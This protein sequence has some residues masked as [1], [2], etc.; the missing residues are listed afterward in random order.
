MSELITAASGLPAELQSLLAEIPWPVVLLSAGGEIL[1]M[2]Q[3]MLGLLGA[4]ATVR[5]G[6]PFEQL[7][8]E[9]ERPALRALLGQVAARR[10]SLPTR[11]HLSHGAQPPIEVEIEALPISADSSGR[12]T[13]N[14]HPF[15]LT[16]RRERLLLEINRLAS[17]LLA[18]QSAD[19]VFNRATEALQPLGLRM[20]VLTLDPNQATLSTSYLSFSSSRAAYMRRSGGLQVDTIRI[21]VE[22]SP[23]HEVLS[24]RKTVFLEDFLPTLRALMAPA[25]AAAAQL[26]AQLQGIRSYIFAPLVE[27][28][29]V[30]GVLVV[31][32]NL[33]NQEDAPFIEAFAHQ[34]SAILGQI[35]LRRQ[36]ETQ[37]QRLNSL[38]ETARA[39]TTLGHLD[40]VLWVICHQA[41][42]LTGADAAAIA[43][44]VTD[45]DC[46]ACVMATGRN[47]ETMIG[48]Q[49]P[50]E[51]S[52][53]GKAFRAG[54][55]MNVPDVNGALRAYAPDRAEPEAHSMLVQ[56]LYHQG[57]ILGVLS[58]G[59]AA[60]ARFQEDDLDYLARYAEYAAIAVANAQLHTDLQ[61]SE[62]EQQRQRQ[63][64][65]ALLRVSDAVNRTLDL[66]T[67]LQEGLRALDDLGLVVAAGVLLINQEQRRL[68][69]RAYRNTP[70]ALIPVVGRPILLDSLSI[71]REAFETG[72]I[73]VLGP[74]EIEP[75]LSYYPGL[76][77]LALTNIVLVPLVADGTPLGLLNISTTGGQ[78]YTERDLRLL[79]AVANQLAQAVAKAQV[80]HA[81]QETATANARLYGQ[82]E[83][84]RRY[85]DALIHNTPD[86]L[87]TI[88]HDMTAHL[89]NPE[90]LSALGGY[91]LQEVEGLMFTRFVPPPH[92]QELEQ[93]WQAA[94]AGEPQT[95]E[96]RLYRADGSLMT[97]LVSA[98]LIPHY[99]EVFVTLKD[100]TEQKQL[101]AQMRQNEKLAA[102][103]RMIAG[104]AHEL[105]NPLAAILGLAQLQLLDDLP[106]VIRS[107][108]EDI[109]RAA[110][111]VHHIV[112]QL[113]TF[114]QPQALKP[115][116]I[117]LAPLINE[118]LKRLAPQIAEHEIAAFIEISHHLPPTVGDPHQI[119][120]VLFNILHN[121]V[122]ALAMNPPERMRRL[123]ILGWYEERTLHLTIDD[124]GPGIAPENLSR[125]FD[126][127]FTTR[128]VGQ[129]TGLG[130]SIVHA[131]V[132]Q[133]DGRVWVESQQGHG[134]TFHIRL[135]IAQTVEHLP[136][137]PPPRLT[138]PA[139]A[140]V[141]LVE[142]ED[143][144]RAVVARA[145]TQ[146]NCQV[147]AVSSG[148]EALQRALNN[149]YA[150]II[151]DLQMPEID[152]PTLYQRVHQARPALRW[153]ILTGDTMG[154]HSRAFL[155]QTGL[156]ALL[157]PFTYEQLA[158]RLSESLGETRQS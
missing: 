95:F 3:P 29:L 144:V 31:W 151:S 85:L 87:L 6:M 122:Q 148:Q 80:H 46:L 111:R 120:Q 38:A 61:D 129:G 121:A 47:A 147:D 106:P 64:L 23:Y 65:A 137:P 92:R 86:M 68:E 10:Q 91:Q 63:A 83:A 19:D 55:G 141:L 71:A 152:G 54:Q 112:Q 45:T 51:E 109:E 150:L 13:L 89:L 2:S 40:D 103:G 12:I 146:L 28:E 67:L 128:V 60:L 14:V 154:E 98:V 156:P 157:K 127:F 81:L 15:S 50:V 136:A 25:A 56:P 27:R 59:Y 62:A 8:L 99:D 104:A 37:I 7:V 130:L 21:P 44:P 126:P 138:R 70:A 105:N 100:V 42:E 110:L 153:L 75:L 33:L 16:H 96:T 84:A 30:T 18:A 108:M 116:T 36:M 57:T 39:V 58:V 133:H 77:E 20:S 118:T 119:E 124:T 158:Q 52:L 107:D 72:K 17:D 88:Q 114:A 131:I 113:R 140:H 22:V 1:A 4:D 43:L 145:L 135:P 53:V 123:A 94:L 26:L 5:P 78:H 41:Q 9:A 134:A 76:A 34:I 82:A 117:A 155:E 48:V 49:V 24:Q 149:D 125:I 101:E 73:Q 66:D 32:S 74:A 93:R 90:R 35:A 11:A 139:G 102:L 69:L 115:Q 79:Q 132:Q 142:D 97:A 143:S